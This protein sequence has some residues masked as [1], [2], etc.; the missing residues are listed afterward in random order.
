MLS[1]ETT[2]RKVIFLTL[3]CLFPL[4]GKGIKMEK[5]LMHMCPMKVI[6]VCLTGFG[7]SNFD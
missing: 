5:Q 1:W 3:F 7:K 6:I 4:I 2:F